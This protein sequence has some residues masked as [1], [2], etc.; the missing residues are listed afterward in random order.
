MQTL[1]CAGWT[2]SLSSGSTSTRH[3]VILC[4]GSRYKLRQSGPVSTVRTELISE[5]LRRNPP[6]V[7]VTTGQKSSTK[8]ICI[9]LQT[10]VL[11]LSQK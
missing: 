8:I 1:S 2:G 7:R 6:E 10:S 11:I 4:Y 9:V 5:V 3:L